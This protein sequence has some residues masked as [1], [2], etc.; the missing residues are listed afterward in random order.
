MDRSSLFE[1]VLS[2]GILQRERAIKKGFLKG[3]RHEIERL[4]E[5]TNDVNVIYKKLLEILDNQEASSREQY[6]Y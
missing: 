2:Q 1:E 4:F 5:E 3:L 6:G